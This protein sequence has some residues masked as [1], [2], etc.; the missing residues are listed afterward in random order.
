MWE[1]WMGRL[2]AVPLEQRPRLRYSRP[3]IEEG[4]NAEKSSHG[5]DAFLTS[6]PR[7]GAVQTTTDQAAAI[8]LPQA[9]HDDHR[10]LRRGGGRTDQPGVRSRFGRSR[11]VFLRQKL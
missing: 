8:P 4:C 1:E 3:A 11:G 2:H 10:G 5:I 6:S 7:R 9:E